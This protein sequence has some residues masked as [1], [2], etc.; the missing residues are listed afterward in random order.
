MAVELYS[1]GAAGE[2]DA[3]PPLYTEQEAAASLG[4]FVSVSYHH[5]F[6]PAGETRAVFLDAG[7][8][9]GSCQVMLEVPSGGGTLRL[10]FSGDLGRKNLPI[11]RDPEPMSPVDDLVVEST[12]RWRIR[13]TRCSSWATW[14]RALW[15][16]RKGL[17]RRLPADTM[18]VVCTSK[19]DRRIP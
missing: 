17:N 3:M 13:P 1:W 12:Y 18:R 10:G 6:R 7:H 4:Q 16:A 8:I 5:P 19:G 15:A 11:L 9:P 2:V 14:R